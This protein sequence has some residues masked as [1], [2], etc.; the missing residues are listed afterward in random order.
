M[1]RHE[2][3]RVDK[4]EPKA[5]QISQACS[6]GVP[7]T[8]NPPIEQLQA[9]FSLTGHG[10]P[11]FLPGNYKAFDGIHAATFVTSSRCSMANISESV[12]SVFDC[13]TPPPPYSR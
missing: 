9:L 5:V 6:L 3:F 12:S 4:T 8:K 11:H 1:K 13:V 7:S 10:L 2:K